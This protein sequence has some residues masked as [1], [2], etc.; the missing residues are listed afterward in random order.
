MK[1]TSA[2]LG[3][4]YTFEKNCSQSLEAQQILWKLTPVH[5]S[6]KDALFSYSMDSSG[7][8]SEKRTGLS[9]PQLFFHD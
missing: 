2:F 7:T 5:L 3:T 1:T 8:N 6:L 9:L 4:I